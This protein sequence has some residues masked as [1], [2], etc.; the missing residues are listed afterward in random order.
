MLRSTDSFQ[1]LV[2]HKEFTLKYS[3]FFN[4]RH[5]IKQNLKEV[6]IYPYTTRK[7]TAV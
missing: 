3:S 1:Y 6:Y 2:T 4:V 5:E 7:Y